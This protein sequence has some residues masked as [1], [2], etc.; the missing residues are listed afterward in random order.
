MKSW[1]DLKVGT[2]IK[3]SFFILVALLVA[4]SGGIY[5]IGHGV[6]ATAQKTSTDTVR[7]ALLAKSMEKDVVQVQQYLSDVSATRGKDGLDDGFNLAKKSY[8]S[9]LEG[10]NR[11][12]S[13]YRQE[14]NEQGLKA[15]SK[16]RQDLD[17]YYKTGRAMAEAYVAGGPEAGNKMMGSFDEAALRISDGIAEFSN[18][19]VSELQTDSGRVV[20]DVDRLIY[21]SLAATGL[22]V[23]ASL[24][25]GGLLTASITKPLGKA[26]RMADAFSAGDLS[27]S[28]DI[29]RS[30][31]I[32]SLVKS[33]NTMGENLRAMF[34]GLIQSVGTLT[35]TS[36][37]LS[38]V[39]AQLRSSTSD[40]STKVSMVSCAA[41]ELST[42]VQSVAAAMEQATMN[43]N[44]VAT[45]T[46]EMSATI[47]EVAQSAEKTRSVT[48]QAVDT[49]AG[50]AK[51]METLGK[52]SEAIGKVTQTIT[53]ISEQTKLLALN[54]TI[55][56][57]RA[58]E[59][60]KGFAVV[61]TEIKELARQTS[62]AT[63]DIAQRISEVQASARQTVGG[64]DQ[65]S[66][67]IRQ[68]DSNVMAIATAVEEQSMTMSEISRNVAEISGAAAEVNVRMAESS[69]A[70]SSV[71][72]EVAGVEQSARE[73]SASAQEVNRSSQLLSDVAERIRDGISRYKL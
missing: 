17:A 27:A 71:T 7:F 67:I 42:N 65:V 50:V 3:L 25:L 24:L 32:G 10:I 12:E 60:G 73:I 43:T 38:A 18:Q 55:E 4:T 31:E 45:A 56:A 2:K 61:A 28:I 26:T 72:R 21:G 44:M 1:D 48:T 13:M 40:T 68:V 19:Q 59:A 63:G 37:E 23:L 49:V 8:E 39:S 35:S 6:S 64:I 16:L 47:R 15:L 57:A 29:R 70:V 62:E 58:G 20:Q 34:G 52:A 46:E 54:A 5:L 36:S 53:E 22:A 9:V 30:D 66:S 41:E 33:L 51:T 11:F 14:G 69:L